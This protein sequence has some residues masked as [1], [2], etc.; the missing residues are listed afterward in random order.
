MK[1][2]IIILL[3]A[4]S[5]IS[6]SKGR[7]FKIIPVDDPDSTRVVGFGTGES[8]SPDIARIRAKS[9]ANMNLLSQIKGLDFN[10]KSS[11]GSIRFKT[12]ASGTL[13][14][15]NELETIQMS[16]N[17]TLMILSAEMDSKPTVQGKTYQ[18]NKKIITTDLEVSLQ[19]HMKIAVQEIIPVTKSQINGKI[20]LSEIDI[21]KE[22]KTDNL[23]VDI[24]FVINLLE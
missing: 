19:N 23:I 8:I 4:L 24:T 9:N 7:T 21:T 6:C 3:I 1:K 14:D 11:D 2:Y 16:E 15:V 20:F 17:K 18:L 12:T 13:K 5:V 10:Y 22:E